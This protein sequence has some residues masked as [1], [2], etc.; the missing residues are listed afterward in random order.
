LKAY[1]NKFGGHWAYTIKNDKCFM[2]IGG[3]S[4]PATPVWLKVGIP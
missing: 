3:L 1:N 4:Y 2:K